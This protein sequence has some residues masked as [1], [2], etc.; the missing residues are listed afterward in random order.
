[1][2]AQLEIAIKAGSHL[3][4]G[5]YLGKPVTAKTLQP[6]KLFENKATARFAA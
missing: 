1:M 3:L 2:Q 5:Y 4:Q 6:S